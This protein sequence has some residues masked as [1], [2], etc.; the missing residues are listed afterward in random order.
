MQL[1]CK[2]LGRFQRLETRQLPSEFR[3]LEAQ[4]DYNYYAQ[5]HLDNRQIRQAQKYP[6][7]TGR[8]ALLNKTSK[9]EQ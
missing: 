4:L 9:Q 2:L 1:Q 7:L 6:K 3:R 5:T 8:A